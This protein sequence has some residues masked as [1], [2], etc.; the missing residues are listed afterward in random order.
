M[1]TASR[2]AAE[3]FAALAD[4]TRLR[5][6]VVLQE[7]GELCACDLETGLEVTQS[8]ASRHLS[9]LRR[10]GLVLDRREGPFVY[11]R[12][13]EPLP[14]VAREALASLFAARL[15]ESRVDLARTKKH[16]RSPCG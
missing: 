4:E 3:L 9:T 6:L 2:D 5:M 12:L 11:Y 15:A 1:P 8:R 16:R 14:H 13:A 7:L 10:A